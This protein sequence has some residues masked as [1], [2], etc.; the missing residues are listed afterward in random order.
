MET[1]IVTGGDVDSVQGGMIS[2]DPVVDGI[3]MDSFCQQQG[4]VRVYAFF[5]LI[6]HEFSKEGHPGGANGVKRESITLFVWQGERTSLASPQQALAKAPFK[7]SP[8]GAL[9]HT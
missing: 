3:L 8:R 6:S 9:G 5:K 4:W 2:L 7:F 1:D